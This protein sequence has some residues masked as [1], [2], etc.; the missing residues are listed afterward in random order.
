S[1]TLVDTVVDSGYLPRFILALAARHQIRE[2]V[3]MISATPEVALKRKL[4]FVEQLRTMSIAVETKTANEQHYEVNVGLYTA[5][6]GP[7][8]K[9]SCALYENGNE[10]LEEAEE[11]MLASYIER[12]ELKDG[13]RIWIVGKC[14]TYRCG[15]GSA[16]F[17]FAEK[18][19]GA[20]IVGFSNSKTQK[21]YIDEQAAK[22][23]LKNIEVITGNI[24]DYEFEPESFDRVVSIEMFE[25]MKNYQA[26]FAKLA[27]ALRPGGKMFAHILAHKDSP[28]HFEEGWMTTHFF[29]GGTMPSSDLFLYFQDDLKIKKH[30]LLSGKH[31][32]KTLRAWLNNFTANKKKVWPTLVEDYGEQN[33]SVWFN[34]WQLYFLACA[35]FFGYDNG[36]VFGIAQ[37]LFEK[38][39]EARPG[40][41]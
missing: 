33:A 32:E 37:Y 7:R 31:Y 30:W 12:G 22:R 40:S 19:P 38:P 26:L 23:G 10:T 14:F 2:R 27:R 35:E 29:T 5:A 3:A 25:H 16:S 17:Y 9:Y 18:L 13:M 11:K 4:E 24:T 21:A 1:A 36:N 34:R 41:S 39:E 6:L 20:K 15:W 8:L 28:Y